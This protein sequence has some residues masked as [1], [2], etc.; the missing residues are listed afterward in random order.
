MLGEREGGE[1]ENAGFM[2]ATVGLGPVRTACRYTRTHTHP[3]V[4]TLTETHTG[5][6]QVRVEDRCFSF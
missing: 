5:S 3:H 1:R 6:M 2:V 4:H